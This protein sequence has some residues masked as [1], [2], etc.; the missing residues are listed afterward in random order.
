MSLTLDYNFRVSWWI[1]TM[2]WR[3]LK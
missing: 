3:K 2:Y 1:F